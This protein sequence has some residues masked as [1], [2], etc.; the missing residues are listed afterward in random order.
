MLYGITGTRNLTPLAETLQG[1]DK[2]T[3]TYVTMWDFPRGSEPVRSRRPRSRGKGELKAFLEQ[4][5][6]IGGNSPARPRPGSLNCQAADCRPALLAA[7]QSGSLPRFVVTT[8]RTTDEAHSSA[9]HG[10]ETGTGV[11]I[12]HAFERAT[13][14]PHVTCPA[15]EALHPRP[16]KAR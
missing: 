14:R 1:L 10:I 13:C 7:K 6:Q 11:W 5:E 15:D 9:L 3:I 8:R 4:S 16:D 2:P 12:F